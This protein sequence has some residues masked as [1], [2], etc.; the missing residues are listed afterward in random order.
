MDFL[1]KVVGGEG[2]LLLLLVDLVAGLQGQVEFV[3][4]VQ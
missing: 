3:I 1:L 4:I 2:L